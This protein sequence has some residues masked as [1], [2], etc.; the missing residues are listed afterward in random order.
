MENW[1]TTSPDFLS[2][3]SVI[4]SVSNTSSTLLPNAPTKMP[5]VYN[6]MSDT[7]TTLHLYCM[8]IIYFSNVLIC[9]FLFLRFQEKHLRLS[10]L[11]YE[12]ATSFPMGT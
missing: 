9:V 12:R 3:I 1:Y 6:Q 11:G 4:F 2:V 10:L 5:N 7:S 8:S